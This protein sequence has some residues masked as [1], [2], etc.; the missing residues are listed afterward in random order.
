MRG[1]MRLYAVAASSLLGLIL[2]GGIFFAAALWMVPEWVQGVARDAAEGIAALAGV[3]FP[4]PQAAALSGPSEPSQVRPEGPGKAADEASGKA[5]PTSA[6]PGLAPDGTWLDVD[7][8]DSSLRLVEGKISLMREA[9]RGEVPGACASDV[10]EKLAAWERIRRPLIDLLETPAFRRDD[11]RPLRR[12]LDIRLIA[13]RIVDRLTPRPERSG[14]AKGDLVRK[15]DPRTLVRLLSED[16]VVSDP[17]AVEYLSRCEPA[18]LQDVIERLSRVAP[19]RAGRLLRSLTGDG[20]ARRDPAPGAKAGGL[21][22][23]M[24]GSQLRG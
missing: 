17:E 7:N 8:L 22:V 20:A 6:P 18:Q 9:S 24:A 15:L 19:E 13:E 23:G 5:A 12:D 2:A 10:E 1:L 21:S 14:D 16:D 4:A 11:A 3:P